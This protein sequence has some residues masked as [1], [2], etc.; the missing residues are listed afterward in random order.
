MTPAPPTI[1]FTRET[2]DELVEHALEGEETEI[3][4]VLA[5][6]YGEERSRVTTLYRT[7]NVAD[8]PRVRYAIDPEEQFAV[9]ERIDEAGDDVVGFYHSHPT[10]PPAPSE[11]DRERASWPDRSYV[12]CSLEGHPFVGSWRWREDSGRF[13]PELLRLR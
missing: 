10:G 12:I 2:Y 8:R 3:C 1:E 11:T 5:G 6:E 4:G 13:E 7:E 9:L